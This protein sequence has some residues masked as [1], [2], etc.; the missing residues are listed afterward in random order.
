MDITNSTTNIIK[1]LDV[2]K[3]PLVNQKAV[4]FEHYYTTYVDLPEKVKAVFPNDSFQTQ[5]GEDN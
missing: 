1:I 3:E 5:I 4:D 2:K